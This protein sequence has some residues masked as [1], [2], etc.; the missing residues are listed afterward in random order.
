MRRRFG[1]PQRPAQLEQI[2]DIEVLEVTYTDPEGSGLG[3]S[4]RG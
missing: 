2:L 1:H 3:I 4:R